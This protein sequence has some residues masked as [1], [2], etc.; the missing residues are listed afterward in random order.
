M[1][2]RRRAGD[3]FYCQRWSS[4][5]IVLIYTQQVIFRQ[6]F[7]SSVHISFLVLFVSILV[8]RDHLLLRIVCVWMRDDIRSASFDIYAY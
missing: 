5:Q 4:Y 2:V 7:F 1:R 3:I 6:F 8:G